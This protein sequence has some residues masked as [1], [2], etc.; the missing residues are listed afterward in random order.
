M[1]LKYYEYLPEKL[2]NVVIIDKTFDEN[3]DYYYSHQNQILL[4]W[5]TEEF[6]NASVIET[7]NLIIYRK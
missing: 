3:P 2:P 6:K 4:D 1:Y 5:I 7:A